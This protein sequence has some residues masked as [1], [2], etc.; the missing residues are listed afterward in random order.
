ML[1]VHPETSS[2]VV[3]RAAM[4]AIDFI[5]FSSMSERMAGA[6]LWRLA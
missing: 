5:V 1:P 6:P 2:T 3:K 4:R